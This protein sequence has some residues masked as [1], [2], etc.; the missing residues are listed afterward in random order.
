M[1]L[2]AERTSKKFKGENSYRPLT[3][4]LVKKAEIRGDDDSVSFIDNK[5]VT[6]MTV[7]GVVR[8]ITR[9]ESFV[10]Y[11]IE[12][13]S[14]AI[15][16]VEW[17]KNDTR[18]ENSM[19]DESTISVDNYVRVSGRIRFLQ[20]KVQNIS[21]LKIS[22]VTD[23]NEIT[24]HLLDAIKIHLSI[25]G[26]LD[27]MSIMSGFKKGEDKNKN[28]EALVRTAIRECSNNEAG[29]YIASLV[30]HL[31]DHLTEAKVQSIVD[32]LEQ[33]GELFHTC[34]NEHIKLVE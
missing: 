34:D 16:A 32:R 27:P 15:D 12:D 24:Y 21:A 8:S 25:E 4:K 20:G 28:E 11:T 18:G 31:K 30:V 7:I 14:G 22:L 10:T 6:D 2:D 26:E 3:I 1:D 13:G 33:K 23:L 17:T 29:A 9:H 19:F 5:K